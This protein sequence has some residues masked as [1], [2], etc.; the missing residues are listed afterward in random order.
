MEKFKTWFENYWYHNK[1]PTIIVITFVL[2]FAI[3]FSQ[4]AFEKT[5]YD[6]Y[7]LYVGATY[8]QKEPKAEIE[9]AIKKAANNVSGTEEDQDVNL[10][11][12]VYLSDETV[13]KKQEE[14]AEQGEVFTY[15]IKE[16]NMVVDTFMKQLVSGENVM[17]IL[18]PTLYSTAE[19]NGALYPVK[20]IF[21]RDMNG[22]N[23][24]GFGI[25]LGESGLTV[26]YPA[27]EALPQDS[28]VCFKK[29]THAMQLV[30]RSENQKSHTFQL[31]VARELFKG[32][33]E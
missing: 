16:N 30:G 17:M 9:K 1:W 22:V 10:Q 19:T 12:L 32:I 33:G 18:D 8:L 20:D 24:S 26:R 23:D 28:I 5:N 13:K 15:N 31:D 21:G 7:T 2:I 3:G 29:V 14:Y 27:F 11:M 4:I 6:V 25:V